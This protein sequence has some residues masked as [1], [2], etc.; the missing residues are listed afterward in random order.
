MP[1][2]PIDATLVDLAAAIH[3]DLVL[4]PDPF[5]QRISAAGVYVG[6]AKLT[7]G[8][9]AIVPRGSYDAA[10]V[11]RDLAAAIPEQV[12]DYS[13]LVPS[14]FWDGCEA[15][16]KTIAGLLPS[17]SIIWGGAHS[18]G[19][20]HLV[21]IAYLLAVV[22]GIKLN[23]VVTF[24]SP[25]QGNAAFKA[26]WDTLG[27][28]SFR[29]RC[30]DDWVTTQPPLEGM[31]CVEPEEAL[32]SIVPASDDPLDLFRYHHLSLIGPAVKALVSAK[33]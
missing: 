8:E 12:P 28:D 20:P 23:R 4:T 21:Y 33:P 17:G 22:H 1:T 30:P 2:I 5:V 13:F 10:D 7:D 15:A 18:L 27:I 19:G 29:Y 16:A 24:E 31:M 11:L 26:A 3:G 32:L 9:Y 6:V 14:G 25:Y